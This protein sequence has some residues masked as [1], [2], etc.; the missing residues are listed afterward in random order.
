V[1]EKVASLV[2]DATT[3]TVFPSSNPTASI[4]DLVTRIMA[5]PPTD[6]LHA[7]AVQILTQ[8]FNDA[9][10]SGATATSAMRSTFS[11]ACQSPS[12]LGLGI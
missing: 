12:S 1:C 6:P 9:K 3:G 10:T 2:V 11:A 5:L 4:E 8:H 7:G